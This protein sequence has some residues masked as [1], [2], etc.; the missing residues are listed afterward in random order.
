M[1]QYNYVV[2]TKKL[3]S[4]TI[5]QWAQNNY[6]VVIKNTTW[7]VWQRAYGAQRIEGQ[8]MAEN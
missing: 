8:N 7:T 2:G 5:M 6:A 3:C 4:N 1:Q